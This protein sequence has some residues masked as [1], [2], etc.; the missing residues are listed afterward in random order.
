M[1]DYPEFVI[2]LS[3]AESGEKH[4]TLAFTLGLKSL[5]KGYRTAII[6]LLDGVEVGAKGCA[7]SIDIGEPFLPVKDMLEV[8]LEQGGQLMICGSCWKHANHTDADRLP[9]ST[10]V[11]ADNVID[12]LM[13]AKSTIQLN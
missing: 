7:D 9:G 11:T 12:F 3:H 8:Y 5:E 1:P 2:T 13:N 10:M 4:V 6:L